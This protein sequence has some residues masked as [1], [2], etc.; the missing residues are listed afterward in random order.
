MKKILTLI[1]FCLVAISC[2]RE[3]EPPPPVVPVQTLKEKLAGKWE[4]ASSQYW[5][6]LFTDQVIYYWQE[7]PGKNENVQ[8]SRYSYHVVKDSLKLH[9]M[10][11]NIKSVWVAKVRTGG[12]VADIRQFGIP[13]VDLVINKKY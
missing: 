9:N 6:F 4:L 13:N 5:H 8:F 12:N 7:N 1:L 11:S 2:R 10:D 3:H